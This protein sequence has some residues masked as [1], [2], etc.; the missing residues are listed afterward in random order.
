MIGWPG[1]EEDRLV[2]ASLTRDDGWVQRPR[3]E[4]YIKEG[5]YCI[6][7]SPPSKPMPCET[8]LLHSVAEANIAWERGC[9]C[10]VRVS[11]RI[12]RNDL[13][14]LLVDV[15]LGFFEHEMAI[16]VRDAWTR[17]EYPVDSVPQWW[18]IEILDFIGFTRNGELADRPT[19]VQTLY[20]GGA[21]WD[22]MSWTPDRELAEWFR[23]RV[24]GRRLW[25]AEVEPAHVLAIYDD[26]RVDER[27]REVEYVVDP[28][29]ITA[30]AIG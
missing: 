19:G 28:S 22:R 13:P 12:P 2:R 20:R 11:Q 25:V 1:S 18:W 6:R 16:A 4:G 17:A 8:S 23:D 30:T 27:G 24:P 5:C 9:R 7:E 10:W 14:A 29:G 15:S 21:S 26:V 3:N